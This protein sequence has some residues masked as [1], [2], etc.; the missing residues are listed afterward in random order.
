MI[1]CNRQTDG[2]RCTEWG[3]WVPVIVM[4]SDGDSPDF[5]G[6]VGMKVCGKHKERVTIWDI[7]GDT[8]YQQLAEQFVKRGKTAPRRDQCALDWERYD[9]VS[10][11]FE[12]RGRLDFGN[13]L[14]P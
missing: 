2:K 5:R 9:D 12:A 14:K 8:G 11:H 6:L 4:R 3:N 10:K 7:L 1:Q 13:G